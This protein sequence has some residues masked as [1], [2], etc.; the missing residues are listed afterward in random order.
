MSRNVLF[1]IFLYLCSDG[2]HNDS[3]NNKIINK[4]A[5]YHFDIRADL[6]ITF[7]RF[8]PAIKFLNLYLFIFINVNFSEIFPASHGTESNK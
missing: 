4:L 3:V 2:F 5:P 8:V 7:D 1:F 6:A